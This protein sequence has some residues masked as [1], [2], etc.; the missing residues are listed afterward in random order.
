MGTEIFDR[1]AVA[2]YQDRSIANGRFVIDADGQ[3][4]LGIFK[5]ESMKFLESG[6]SSET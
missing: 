4:G 6:A 3:A 2:M 5:D 1:L